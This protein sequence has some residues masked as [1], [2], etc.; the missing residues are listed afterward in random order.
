MP[1]HTYF[2]YIRVSTVRQGQTGTSLDEQ[3]EA[4]KRYAER[5]NLEI[6][7]EFEEQETAAKLGRPIFSSMLK[8]LK[9]G[10]ARG[11][12]I[13]KIDRS[14]RNLKDWANLGELIDQGIEVHFA[15]ESL[16]LQSRGGRL[17][18]D[19]QAVVAADYIRNL[20]EETKKGFYGRLKQGIYPCPA[21]IGYLNCGQGKPKV[22][23]P[24][25][26]HLVKQAFELYATGRWP[27]KALVGKV[28]EIGLRTKQDKKMTLS[29]VAHMLHNQF[30]TG[31]I[32]IK[33]KRELFAGAHQPIVTKQLF[34][35][36]QAVFSG[37]RIEKRLRHLM[38]FRKLM[39]CGNCGFRL[40][41]ETKK[42]FIYYRCHTKECPQKSL[43]EDR[44]EE[45]FA[46]MLK[47]LKFSDTE[48]QYLKEQIKE[49]HQNYQSLR[50]SQ[51][52]ALR[53][54]LDQVQARRSKLIDAYIDG[55]LEQETYVVKKNELIVEEKNIKD[56]LDQLDSNQQQILQRIEQFL[57][58]VNDAYASYQLATREEKRELIRTITSD[59]TVEGKNIVFK[60]NMPF[61]IV[62]ERQTFFDGGPRRNRT[63][64]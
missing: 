40:I 26:A 45:T 53:L 33:V 5:N 15:N 56:Q 31:L 24:V 41:G 37:K 63:A 14:A 1:S 44:V 54:Q 16:D 61:R 10:K 3:R 27:L 21:P 43:R 28:W 38:L 23:D 57:E 22:P 32:Y 7:Q 46:E 29:G 4:I 50:V 9:Q 6:I 18:A 58:L 35:R 42:G 59:A 47:V 17:S 19:I 52:Q 12:I 62:I 39:R 55:V 30:Y 25:R 36:V 13:H 11:V 48:N 49:A 51:A 60:L 2:S 8:G 34:D 64:A 20:K